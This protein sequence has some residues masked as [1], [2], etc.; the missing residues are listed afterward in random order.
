[1]RTTAEV[2][3]RLADFE[4]RAKAETKAAHVDGSRHEDHALTLEL[5]WSWVGALT[6]VLGEDVS[7]L[8]LAPPG[9]TV[10]VVDRTTPRVQNLEWRVSELEKRLPGVKA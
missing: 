6:W 1:M 8:A 10:N 3:E 2:K 5:L 9:F 7:A 4:T